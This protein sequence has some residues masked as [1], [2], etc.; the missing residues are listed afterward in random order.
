MFKC[1]FY[2][3]KNPKRDFEDIVWSSF[4]QLRHLFGG[5]PHRLCTTQLGWALLDVW[6]YVFQFGG[7]RGR[8]LLRS[9]QLGV[10]IETSWKIN[11][12]HWVVD[13]GLK[14]W[15]RRWHP[16]YTPSYVGDFFHKPWNNKD[17]VMEEP[18]W[19]MESKGLEVFFRGWDE[20][21]EGLK[22]FW[23]PWKMISKWFFEQVIKS[24][25]M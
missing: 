14:T 15:I 16:N 7:S 18:G 19:L 20:L 22:A 8:S 4:H 24:L 9:W 17:P 25:L 10:Q 12:P 1:D 3:N 11:Q 5:H 2:K 21:G 6:I 13:V 23:S